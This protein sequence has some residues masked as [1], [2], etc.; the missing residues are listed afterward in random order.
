MEHSEPHETKQKDH[1]QYGHIPKVILR[2]V[3]SNLLSHTLATGFSLKSRQRQ[4]KHS[5]KNIRDN[6]HNNQN[7]IKF[8]SY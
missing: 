3:I 2:K 8:I 5:F 7:S 6:D 1:I 4:M